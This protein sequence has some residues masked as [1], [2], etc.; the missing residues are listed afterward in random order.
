[1]PLLRLAPHIEAGQVFKAIENAISAEL[2]NDTIVESRRQS[3]LAA[4]VNQS[5]QD[6][7]VSFAVQ[8]GQFSVSCAGKEKI[9]RS[10]TT[11]TL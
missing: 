1:M 6:S 11:F 10:S 7:T 9:K 2:I 8:M 5:L 3:Q 4:T